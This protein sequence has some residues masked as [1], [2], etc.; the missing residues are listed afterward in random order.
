MFPVYSRELFF[1]F[2]LCF[3]QL[4]TEQ[5]L[6]SKPESRLASELHLASIES[7]ERKD[8]K[9]MKDAAIGSAATMA[10]VGLVAG[11]ASLL[12]KRH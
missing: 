9:Q 10:A 5:I 12:L 11:L 6:R 7:K 3:V 8:A 2:P 1:L 4:R